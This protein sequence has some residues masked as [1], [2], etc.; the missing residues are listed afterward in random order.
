MHRRSLVEKGAQK[1]TILRPILCILGQPGSSKDRKQQA[2]FMFLFDMQPLP[3]CTEFKY[4]GATIN[5]FL[6]YN[7][8]ASCLAYYTGR[9]LSSSITKLIKHE[10]YLTMYT[11]NCMIRVL[12]LLKGVQINRMFSALSRASG[13]LGIKVRTFCNSP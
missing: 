12:P 3:Y 11:Q 10:G 2:M 5:K 1:L 6:D 7:Y 9:A 13:H 8:A 4:L